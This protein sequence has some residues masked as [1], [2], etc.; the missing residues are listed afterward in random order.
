MRPLPVL[1]ASWALTGLGAALG[2]VLG[3][4]FGSRGTFLGQV[5][6]GVIAI[7]G[8]VMLLVRVRWLPQGTPLAAT[9]GGLVGL[10]VAAPLVFGHP[11]API[12]LLFGCGLVGAGVLVGA[13]MMSRGTRGS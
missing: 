8:T 12:T 5:A 4:A 11:N 7:I 9:L 2:S 1:L 13:G 3:N 10:A 6:G